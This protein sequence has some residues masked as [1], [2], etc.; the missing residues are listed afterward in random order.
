MTKH[1]V[2]DCRTKAYLE[3]LRPEDQELWRKWQIGWC[4]VYSAGLAALIAVGLLLL[5]SADTQVAKG[6][7]ATQQVSVRLDR[8]R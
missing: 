4:C 8:L 3:Y 7:S 5:G 6:A 1:L 2:V